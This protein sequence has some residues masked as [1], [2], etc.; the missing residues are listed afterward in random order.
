MNLPYDCIKG[1]LGFNFFSGD[2]SNFDVF[3]RIQLCNLL[4]DVIYV[5]SQLFEK[6]GGYDCCKQSYSEPVAVLGCH[7]G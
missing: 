7:P 3:K 2:G 4:I 6:M 5:E 1:T